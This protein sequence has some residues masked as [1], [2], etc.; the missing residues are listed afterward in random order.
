MEYELRVY[1]IM[2]TKILNVKVFADQFILKYLF[3][4]LDQQKISLLGRVF[5]N[6]LRDQCSIPG[7]V[8]PKTQKMVINAALLNTQHFKVQI[9]GKVVQ[10][11]ERSSVLP[12]PRCCN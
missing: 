10:S 8:R 7:R 6:D 11:S 5:P 9:K 3:L 2:K 12:T 1:Q 4:S